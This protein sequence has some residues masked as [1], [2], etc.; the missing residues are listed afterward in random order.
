LVDALVD[1][2]FYVIRYDNR[3]VGLS[4]KFEDSH[5]G[6]FLTTFLAATQGDAVDVPYLLA[7]M[8]A[9]AVGL[10]DALD[11][12]SA[13]VVGVSMG[14]MIAQ[15]VAIEHP[16]RVRTL[17]SIMSTTGE[18]DVGQ[19][20]PEAMGALMAP[21]PTNRDEAIAA[22]VAS[23]KVIGSPDH[24]DE[25]HVRD[26]STRAYDRCW[27]PAGTARHLL[28]IVSSGSRAEALT[29]LDV[30]TLVIHGDVDPLV[31]PTGGQRTA[32]LI[33]SAELVMLEGMGHD[34]PTAFTGP[35]VEAI[36]GLVA[37]ASR[38]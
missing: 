14:G 4:S 1:R 7:D 22:G 29:K 9:D 24:F 12:V 20:S 3:D 31:R 23:R 27:N 30:P 33:P 10:L 36:T 18:L 5:G 37:R 6:D 25:H 32:E 26:L 28:A 35:I 13:H 34:L 2:G 8:A 17:T 21:I 11:I 38:V 15:T 16:R 19:P